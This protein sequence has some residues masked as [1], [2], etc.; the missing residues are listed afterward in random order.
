MFLS[1][2]IKFFPLKILLIIYCTKSKIMGSRM[3]CIGFQTVVHFFFSF[4]HFSSVTPIVFT[5]FTVKTT[6]V[7]EE[8]AETW[9]FFKGDILVAQ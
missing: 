7:T 5:G 4:Y 8:E 3:V 2:F 9:A 1:R 6:G